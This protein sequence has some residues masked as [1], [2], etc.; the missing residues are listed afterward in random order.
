MSRL[1]VIV[2]VPILVGLGFYFYTREDPSQIKNY[3]GQGKTI[4]AF[5]D[6]LVAGTGA[7]YHKEFVSL[8]SEKLRI[9]I[10]NEGVIGNTTRDGLA[11]IDDVLKHDPKLVIILLG[12]N[13]VLRKISKEETFQNLEKIVQK[14]QDS[15]SMVLLIGIQ[16]GVLRDP[17][18][19]EFEALSEKYQT[20][21]VESVLNGMIGKP[22]Y[23]F[24]AIHPND[25]GY[26]KIADRLYPIV[27]RMLF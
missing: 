16:G 26:A 6:S 9:P 23:M 14:V 21:Y 12:G 4:V 2:L 13:D 3:P 8:L 19:E 25:V 5:G 7:T 18:K 17:Y 11:R 15:G 20:A 10:I 1:L 22:E 27:I 24:D